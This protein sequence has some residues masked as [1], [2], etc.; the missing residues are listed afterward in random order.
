M[1]NLGNVGL[2]LH[3]DTGLAALADRLAARLAD[4][5]S[6]PLAPELVV[7]P[8]EGVRSWLTHAISTRLGICS[9]IDFVY[10]AAFVREV[11]GSESGLGRWGVGPLTWVIQSLLADD[12][13]PDALRARAIAD[14]FDRYGLYRTHMANAWTGGGEVNGLL[15]PLAAHQRWQPELW[16]RV[17]ERLGGSTDVERVREL[18]DTIRIEGPPS[19]V[20]IPDR[21]SVFG[22]TS[23]PQPH[24]E[25]LAALAPHRD[26]AIFSPV[27]SPDRWHHVRARSTDRILHPLARE[28]V[29]IDPACHRLNRAWGRSS[30]EG[31]LLLLDM[32]R[33]VAGEVHAP[34]G[35]ATP[36]TT[37]LGHLRAGISNDQAPEG[38]VER[39]GT[40][41]WHRTFG[42]ARQVEVLRDHLLHLFDTD[43][44][45]P[46]LHARDIVIL[47]P[48]VE[49]FAP[50]VESVFAG[51]PDN[52]LPAIPVQ[53]ADRSLGAENP[54]ATAALAVM[55][56]LNG[57]F[58]VDDVIDLVTLPAVADRFGLDT[59]DVDRIARLLA[60]AN[61][62][63]GLDAD[64]QAEAGVPV[65]GAYTLGDALDRA[66]AGALTGETGPEL[67]LGQVAP[68]DDVLFDDVDAIGSV[69]ACLDALRVIHA[70]LAEPLPAS[71]WVERFRVALHQIIA[72]DDDMT[73]LWRSIDRVLDDVAESVGSA[74][75]EAGATEID[76]AE[77]V[78]LLSAGLSST[79]G[80]PRFDTGR[81]TLSSLTA[82]RGVPHRVVCLLG[83]DLDSEPSGFG[84][85]DDLVANNPCVGDRDARSEYRSQILDAVMAA[86]EALIMCSTGFDVRSRAEIAPSV[87][88]SEL[89]DT[90]GDLTG[91][92]FSA[93]DHPRQAWS[94]PSFERHMII[95]A[96]PW[97]HD[98]AAAAAALARRHQRS[99]VSAV[100]V[101]P[102]GEPETEI[103]LSDLAGALTSPVKAFCEGRLGVYLR[104]RRD[105]STE[106]SIPLS[107][108]GL[109]AYA[110]RDRVLAAALN[111]VDPADWS[112]YLRLA[113]DIPPGGYGTQALEDASAD[114]AAIVDLLRADSI[115]LP[116]DR[117]T[118]P[119]SIPASDSRGRI[120]GEV[121]DVVGTVIVDA[122][123]SSYKPGHLLDRILDLAALGMTYPE[124]NW[125]ALIYRR[126]RSSSDRSRVQVALRD[127]EAAATLIEIISQHRAQ[128]LT[129][130]V[131]FF[132]DLAEHLASGAVGEAAKK[133]TGRDESPGEGS[134]PWNRLFYDHTFDELM[135]AADLDTPV[136]DVWAPIMRCV[137]IDGASGVAS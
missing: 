125:S 8:G 75:P 14:L 91:E 18:V 80:R 1:R 3:V 11:L 55:A 41:V 27:I 108:G 105:T 72:V 28:A 38:G 86:G 71:V 120:D 33:E 94:E 131:A 19:G 62:R 117:T 99:T 113:G 37:L 6:N 130:P 57:R 97:S 103:R 121:P 25:V 132:P 13:A 63:W 123:A 46:P 73:F 34:A 36:S 67:A 93:I 116:L 17:N 40:V 32:V 68:A 101:L 16:R 53:V 114:V 136:N 66:V 70:E 60:S 56:L 104:E 52:G 31:H 128:A 2:H 124:T 81:V 84:S 100:P 76:P 15:E 20:R 77:M 59:D 137:V 119:V 90:L 65:L 21:I 9:N 96:Q 129:T 23:I 83:M 7:I 22:I 39:D 111:D 29:G 127:S 118:L 106:S 112:E 88:L 89:I 115:V 102:P 58:R 12:G 10:P 42:P 54:I 48:D 98:A 50:I 109:D 44:C 134:K 135:R 30:D 110:L 64:D 78:A 61:A 45:D 82:L 69:M 47:T 74:G 4:V 92:P 35:Q 49:R 87:A 122:R 85:P 133:W 24:L 95:S 5:P 126:A 51:D 107:L 79:A 26:V 43:G